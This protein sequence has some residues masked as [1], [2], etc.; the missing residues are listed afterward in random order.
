MGRREPE[1]VKPGRTPR[2]L[3]QFLFMLWRQIVSQR[4]WLL[5]PL[6]VLLALIGLLLILTGN[7]HLLPA[8]Y[9]AF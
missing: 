6:W 9:I 8:I 2:T 1:P 4:R 3:Q 7:P 5:I